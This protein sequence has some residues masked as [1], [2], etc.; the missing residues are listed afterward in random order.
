MGLPIDKLIVATNENDILYRAI[1]NGDYISRKVKETLSPSMDIQLASNF[2]RLI[3][4]VNNSN[5]EITSNIMKKVKNNE[6]RIEK[7]N[8]DIIQKDFVSESC[9]EDETLKI[10]K[11][12]F[13]KIVSY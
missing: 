1:S 9:D 4:Y 8:L 2:E 11:E 7:S 12:N 6:Y 3:Y 10:I 13:E 5:S